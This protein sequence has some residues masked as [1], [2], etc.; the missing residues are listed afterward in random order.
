MKSVSKPSQR[1]IIQ[2]NN[3]EDIHEEIIFKDWGIDV[4]TVLRIDTKIY[5]KAF[6]KPYE[7]S[8]YVYYGSF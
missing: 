6:E 8:F 4:N 1:R 3:V 5:H 2:S 7:A